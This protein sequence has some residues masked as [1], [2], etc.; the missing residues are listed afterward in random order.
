MHRRELEKR[1]VW[2]YGDMRSTGNVTG[3]GR[4]AIHPGADI[5]GKR[6][7][8]CSFLDIYDRARHFRGVVRQGNHP[9]GSRI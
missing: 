4:F 3:A 2:P 1:Q 5:I 8:Y 7:N 6:Q 9:C